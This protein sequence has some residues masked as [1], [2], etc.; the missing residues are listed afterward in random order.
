MTFEEGRQ[1]HQQFIYQGF[2]IIHKDENLKII[3]DFLLT[4]DIKFK[5]AVSFPNIS[6]ERLDEI[7]YKQLL[8]KNNPVY[9]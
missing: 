1:K 3:F 6:K 8:C 4:P 9:F 5:P 7:D 2:E